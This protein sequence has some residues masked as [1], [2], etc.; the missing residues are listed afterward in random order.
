MSGAVAHFRRSFLLGALGGTLVVAIAGPA[1]EL[2]RNGM[3]VVLA[4][5]IALS[6][7]LAFATAATALGWRLRP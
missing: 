7:V 1:D 4:A 3:S 5:K 6:Y 2:L